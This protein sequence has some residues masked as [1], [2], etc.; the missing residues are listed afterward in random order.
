VTAIVTARTARQEDEE[1]ITWASKIFGPGH[2][3]L[4]NMQSQSYI[5][6]P[7]IASCPAAS[8]EHVVGSQLFRLHLR[9]ALHWNLH[10]DLLRS[11][12]LQRAHHFSEISYLD[13]GCEVLYQAS[14]VW[15]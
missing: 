5:H 13:P 2:P 6:S 14:R 4:T 9:S 10:W 3:A 11:T 8:K 1:A 7:D 15:Q 12:T